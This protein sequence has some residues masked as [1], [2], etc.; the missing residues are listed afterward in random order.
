MWWQGAKT[1]LFMHCMDA[2]QLWQQQHA[3]QE[4]L[5]RLISWPRPVRD[6]GQNHITLSKPWW[7]ACAG[8]NTTVLLSLPTGKGWADLLCGVLCCTMWQMQECAVKYVHV[9]TAVIMEKLTKSSFTQ[10]WCIKKHSW[11]LYQPTGTWEGITYN[12]VWIC[13]ITTRKHSSVHLVS[14]FVHMLFNPQFLSSFITCPSTTVL[15]WLA[16]QKGTHSPPFLN[17]DNTQV[18]I[19]Q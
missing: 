8:R 3:E 7:Q 18:C 13:H 14:S 17:K 11:T 19:R 5:A 4:W 15:Y 9:P 12:S 16:K 2:A 6:R 10:S 1:Q